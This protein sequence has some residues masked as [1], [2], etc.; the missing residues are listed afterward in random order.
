M[1]PAPHLAPCILSSAHDGSPV[2]RVRRAVG[3]QL[4]EHGL[5]APLR[6]QLRRGGGVQGAAH[7]GRPQKERLVEDGGG[8]GPRADQLLVLQ[9]WWWWRCD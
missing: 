7:N 9:G 1:L 3:P 4:A 2:G 6:A 5:A 8:L